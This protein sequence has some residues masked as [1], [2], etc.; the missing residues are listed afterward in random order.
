MNNTQATT[1]NT[2]VGID[3]GTSGVKVVFVTPGGRTLAAA[4]RNYETASPYDG[5]A[6][7]D[8]DQWWRSTIEAFRDASAQAS[9]AE[10]N[11]IEVAGIGLT[12]QMHSFVLLD[13]DNTP[14]RP[15]I[16]WMDARA[17]NLVPEISATIDRGGF[18]QSVKNRVA[19]GLTLSPFVWVSRHEPR[20]LE[21]ARKLLFAKDYLRFRLTG[22]LRTDI[23]DA[24]GSLLL[25]IPKRRW[26]G[27]LLEALALPIGVLPEIVNPWDCAGRVTAAAA[28]EL[29]LNRR[30][31]VA[32]GAADQQA[33]TL[34]T[35]VLEPGTVQLMLG[36]GVQVASPTAV[37]D[38]ELPESLNYFCH[39][40]GWLAQGSV[41]NGGSALTWVRTVLQG[42]WDEL[43]QHAGR[44]LPQGPFFL[45][46]LTGE[47]TP[48]MDEQATGAWFKL[49]HSTARS[50]LLYAGCEGV[51][52]TALDAVEA[53]FHALKL[54]EQ[55]EIRC[56]GGGTRMEQYSQLVCDALGRPL[57]MLPSTDSTAI[58][59][60]I[61]GGVA[62]HCFGGLEQAVGA[63]G[64]SAGRV[65]YPNTERHAA[66]RERHAERN[67]LRDAYLGVQIR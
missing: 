56:S 14:V 62:A 23:T 43:E 35:G 60:A 6:E 26:S 19:A 8:P 40:H 57:T 17:R 46:Y 27:E 29:G 45:P 18:K 13:G 32:V 4:T 16:V 42:E 10:P 47:R 64:I 38:L 39:H 11:G 37:G 24:S 34:A 30:P 59:A 54:S 67:K 44:R 5:W 31:W 20:L 15:A 1:K 65:V 58:G 33:S 22:D 49:R 7:Q 48:V 63:M 2:L 28:D 66:L 51:A 52:F 50:D 55:T 53:V 41:Q 3:L 9:L 25:D 61:L 12:G 36:T 21:R